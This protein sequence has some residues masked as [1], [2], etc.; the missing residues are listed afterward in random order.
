[1]LVEEFECHRDEAEE[2][3]NEGGIHVE[4]VIARFEENRVCNFCSC[5]I[6]VIVACT[7]IRHFGDVDRER[8]VCGRVCFTCRVMCV[9]ARVHCDI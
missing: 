3:I 7:E 1:L 4:D 2:G 9:D 5:A 6:V 8:I